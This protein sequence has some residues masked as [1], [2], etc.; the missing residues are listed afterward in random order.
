MI[1]YH[2]SE[3]AHRLDV[4]VGGERVWTRALGGVYNNELAGCILCDVTIDSTSL[5]LILI[6]SFFDV[7]LY[8]CLCSTDEAYRVKLL[9]MPG[10]S[11]SDYINASY[12]D[13][14][15]TCFLLGE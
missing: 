12:V 3:A 15:E 8:P 14:S 2:V 13:V 7:Q 4:F 11:G 9:M 5:H 10:V 6:V 1:S